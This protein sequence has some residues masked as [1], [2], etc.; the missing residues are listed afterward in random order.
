MNVVDDTN[1]KRVL[2]V[3][4]F[5][6]N[7]TTDISEEDLST[8]EWLIYAIDSGIENLEGMQFATGM[9]GLVINENLVTK[10][11]QI[12]TLSNLTQLVA[13]NN[14]IQGVSSL[15]DLT[16]IV[17][18][19]LSHNQ[20][21]NCYEIKDLIEHTITNEN[22]VKLGY[23]SLSNQSI[24]H[25][26]LYATKGSNLEIDWST[27]GI[28]DYG[29]ISPTVTHVT[30]E[31]IVHDKD[32]NIIKVTNIQKDTPIQ[33]LFNTGSITVPF[34]GNVSLTIQLIPTASYVSK[35]LT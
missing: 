17:T 15:N 35:R 6:R 16:S 8:L 34:N 32:T 19:D 30:G 28:Y 22:K 4:Y 12:G 31:N 33:I 10:I 7:P 29:G 27:F 25:D 18:L 21:G 1:L 20:I 23:I 5:K 9:R 24:Q 3:E 2:N 13:N 14:Q 26:P 11:S